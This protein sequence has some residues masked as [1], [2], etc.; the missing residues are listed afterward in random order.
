M[1]AI[2]ILNKNCVDLISF[3]YEM[4]VVPGL[5]VFEM[6]KKESSTQNIPIIF[7]TVK[8]DEATL[9]KVLATKPE[10]Y[11][12]KILSTEDLVKNIGDFFK[13]R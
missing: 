10:K 2:F 9:M 7:L 4:F 6:L 3:D 8:D 1:N 5:Q 12:V 13:V 11:L